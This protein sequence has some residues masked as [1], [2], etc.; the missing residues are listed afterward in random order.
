MP[1]SLVFLV[2]RLHQTATEYIR[3]SS[4]DSEKLRQ[5]NADVSETVHNLM[6]LLKLVRV[7]LAAKADLVA[8]YKHET[9][10]LERL[11]ATRVASLHGLLQQ[12]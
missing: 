12:P 5:I 2:N 9:A 8:L 1:R 6:F 11:T 4:L 10:E 3:Y 7:K